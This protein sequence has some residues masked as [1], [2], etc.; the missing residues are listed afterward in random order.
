M[1]PL[2]NSLTRSRDIEEKERDV[3]LNMFQETSFRPNQA[4]LNIH[5]RNCIDSSIS[6]AT[7]SSNHSPSRPLLY[8]NSEFAVVPLLHREEEVFDRL[9]SCFKVAYNINFKNVFSHLCPVQSQPWLVFY[10]V[11][12]F[13]FSVRKLS[14]GHFRFC[15]L[16]AQF[17]VRNFWIC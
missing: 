2:S 4:V 12:K 8:K 17:S 11:F 13:T 9:A 10:F 5:K 15:R 3:F 7:R 1:L 6:Y 14:A 16:I